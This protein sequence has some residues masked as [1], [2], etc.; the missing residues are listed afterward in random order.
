MMLCRHAQRAILTE[1]K[2][3]LS[4][5]RN[6][7]AKDDQIKAMRKNINTWVAKYRREERVAGRPSYG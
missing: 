5:D 1:V 7:P 3:V 2:T 4:L 6:D